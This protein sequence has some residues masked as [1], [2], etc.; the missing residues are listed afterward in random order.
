[1]ISFFLTGIPSPSTKRR[2][3]K[4]GELIQ[5]QSTLRQ[6]QQKHRKLSARLQ[7][8][9]VKA[10]DTHSPSNEFLPISAIDISKNQR[11]ERESVV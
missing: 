8:S 10:N 5:R 7:D 11:M 9:V 2:K 3:T 4:Q 1:M 6:L